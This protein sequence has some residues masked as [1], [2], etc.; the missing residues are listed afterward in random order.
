M[1]CAARLE[2]AAR[3]KLT[4]RSKLSDCARVLAAAEQAQN[5]PSGGGS[6]EFPRPFVERHGLIS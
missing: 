5:Q 6:L 3:G 2:S 1:Q 4:Q